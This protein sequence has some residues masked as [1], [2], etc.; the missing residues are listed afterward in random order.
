MKTFRFDHHNR[1][2]DLL[3]R[4]NAPL[5]VRTNCYFGGGTA[6]VLQNGEYR[7]SRDV[8]FICADPTG[9]RTLREAT[10]ASGIA[11]LFTTEIVE[12]RDTRRD[13]YG[14][15]TIVEID[16]EPISF[17]IVREDRIEVTGTMDSDLNVPVLD[18]ASQFAEKLLANADRATDR[19]SMNRDAVDLAALIRAHGFVPQEAVE[20]TCNA[21]GREI[22]RLAHKASE[23]LLDP[24]RARDV[25]AGL[26]MDVREVVRAGTVLAREADRVWPVA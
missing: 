12:L 3:G 15:R 25:A 8:D 16:G 22:G 21:Y 17:E 20:R 7:L 11:G 18:T 23:M 14:I 19:S 1:V 2:T 6:I 4:L 13:R 24:V 5:L 9:Y 26:S 10:F